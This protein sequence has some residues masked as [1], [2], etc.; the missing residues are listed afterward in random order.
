MN[1][2]SRY[3]G[4]CVPSASLRGCT[5]TNPIDQAKLWLTVGMGFVERG[6][7]ACDRGML[8]GSTT[9]LA[10]QQSGGEDSNPRGTLPPLPVLKSAWICFN[11]GDRGPSA[12][13]STSRFLAN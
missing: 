8:Y 2:C 4:S 12:P 9:P 6:E 5:P 3:Q 11:H 1:L 7:A 13:G 10:A